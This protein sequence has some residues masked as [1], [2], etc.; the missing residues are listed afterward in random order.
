MLFDY[1]K[2]LTIQ[3]IT[4]MTPIPSPIITALKEDTAADYEFSRTGF[5]TTVGSIMAKNLNVNIKYI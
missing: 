2:Q 3:S 1:S 5:S 4:Q